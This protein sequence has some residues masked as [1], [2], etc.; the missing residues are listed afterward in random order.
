MSHDEAN[1]PEP[2]RFLPRRWL[3]DQREVSPHP[4][5]SI[6]FGYG[7]RACVGR[8]IAELEMHLALIRIIQK[9]LIRPDPQ[10]TDVKP[11]SRIVLV[12]DKPI[13]LDFLDR[14]TVP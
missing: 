12:P 10:C 8:R 4:F 13:N 1:F 14:Q 6:P 3:R 7:I 5:S 9:F 11:L 2:E